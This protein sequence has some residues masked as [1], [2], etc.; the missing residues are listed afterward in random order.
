MVGIESLD[1]DPIT[2][3]LLPRF[4]ETR[5]WRLGSGDVEVKNAPEPK[6]GK[7]LSGDTLIQIMHGA[8]NVAILL[9]IS[10]KMAVNGKLFCTTNVYGDLGALEEFNVPGALIENK[11]GLGVWPESGEEVTARSIERGQEIPLK[12]S[13]KWFSEASANL[14]NICHKTYFLGKHEYLSDIVDLSRHE[15]VTTK[16]WL[17]FEQA[18]EDLFYKMYP[19]KKIKSLAMD[20]RDGFAATAWITCEFVE[21]IRE[22]QGSIGFYSELF[23]VLGLISI[24]REVFW[25]EL[26]IFSPSERQMVIN[27]WQWADEE[28]SFYSQQF[29]EGYESWSQKNRNRGRKGIPLEEIQAVIPVFLDVIKRQKKFDFDTDYELPLNSDRALE[30]SFRRLI[31]R[32]IAIKMWKAPKI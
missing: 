23:D 13:K 5:A 9:A 18:R 32:K 1:S 20:S 22:V 30:V 6:R 11:F 15:A 3:V 24:Y 19:C 17:A 26:I 27:L 8:K 7:V 25:P 28:Y 31:L 4:F 21:M 2:E 14:P 16:Q 10:L 12:L 29:L